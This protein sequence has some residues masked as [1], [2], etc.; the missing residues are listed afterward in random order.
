[1]STASSVTLLVVA[2]LFGVFGVILWS[3]KGTYPIHRYASFGHTSRIVDILDR[4]PALVNARDLWRLTPLQYAAAYGQVEASKTLLARGAN[5]DIGVGW[6]PLQYAVCSGVVQLVDLLANHADVNGTPDNC[7][8]TALHVAA[9][10][11]AEEIAKLLLKRGANANSVDERGNTP[12]HIAAHIG[13]TSVVKM[14][15]KHG[16]SISSI[17]LAGQ[18]PLTVAKASGNGHVAQLLQLTCS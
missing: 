2:I 15:V 10:E 16:A 11:S 18:T 9:A 12:L 5:C 8:G 14:L 4:S 7:L 13:S 3:R 17:N 1:M 6:T